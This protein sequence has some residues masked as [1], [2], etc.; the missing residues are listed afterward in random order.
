MERMGR[1]VEIASWHQCETAKIP[2]ITFRSLLADG[3][4]DLW[5]IMSA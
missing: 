2:E 4:A 3:G 1:S 5:E